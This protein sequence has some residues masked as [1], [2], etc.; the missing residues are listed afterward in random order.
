[1][2]LLHK[3]DIIRIVAPARAITEDELMSSVH[4]L[5]EQGYQVEFGDHL[6]CRHHQFAGTD[7]ERTADFQDALDTERVKVVWCARGGYGC[8]RIIDRLDFS[9]FALAPKWVCGYSDVTVFHTYINSIL[10]QPS[11]HAIMPV[12]VQGSEAAFGSLRTMLSALE[13][14]E[15][16]YTVAVHPLNRT[17]EAKGELCGGNLS[18]LYA[19]NGSV[20]DLNT[21]GKILFIEDLDEYLY[22]ID[23]IMMCLKRS[24]KL[25][26]LSGLVVGGMEDMHD[27]AIAYG[28]SVEEIIWEHVEEYQYPVCFGFP[29]GHIPDNRALI[30]GGTSMLKVT[31]EHVQFQIRAT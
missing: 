5:Q 28:K 14:G 4:F 18:V 16:S 22:H 30:L 29:A 27:N 11:L 6:F 17:G 2:K 12:N 21:D 9:K 8:L 19:V 1:M 10:R 26:N 20:S 31:K 23:R 15:V 7:A 3:G 25:E 13:T 24:G